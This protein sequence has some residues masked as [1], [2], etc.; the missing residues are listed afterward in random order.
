[1]Q[2]KRK[3]IKAHEQNAAFRRSNPERDTWHTDTLGSSSLAE[4][5]SGV[6]FQF[7]APENGDHIHK[8]LPERHGSPEGPTD[9]QASE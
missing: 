2:R 6:S 1:M 9:S 7:A 8:L 4:E 3:R 5:N